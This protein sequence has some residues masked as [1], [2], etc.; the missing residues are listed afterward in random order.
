MAADTLKLP[1]VIEMAQKYLA[2][3]LTVENFIKRE[4]ILKGLAFRE[5]KDLEKGIVNFIFNNLELVFKRDDIME[6]H[7]DI[8]Y[9]VLKNKK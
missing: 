7:K 2:E 9:Q 1:E 4:K 5:C 3:G 8:F 6:V